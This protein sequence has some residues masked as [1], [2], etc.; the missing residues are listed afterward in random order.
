MSDTTHTPTIAEDIAA[1]TYWMRTPDRADRFT[2]ED[3]GKWIDTR[4]VSAM[5][6]ISGSHA[7][8]LAALELIANGRE[9]RL[10]DGS[11]VMVDLDD[12]AAV[13]RAAIAQAKGE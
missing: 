4:P 8:M 12:P 11:T 6:R 10:D 2:L 1:V 13:A 3:A 5:Q 9:V 7:A